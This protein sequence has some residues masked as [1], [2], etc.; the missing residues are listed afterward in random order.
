[1]SIMDLGERF[2]RR[3]PLGTLPT[4]LH[5]A[6]LLSEVGGVEVDLKRDDLLGD[7]LT[8]TKMRALSF[9]LWQAI[10]DR[11]TDLITIGE[12]TSNQCR[13]VAMLGA[14]YGMTPH[15]LLRKLKCTGGEADSNLMIMRMHGARLHFLEEDE[16]RLHGMT[17]KRLMS[18]VR[19]AK[20]KAL[21]VPFGCGG[22]PGVLGIVGLFD[23][24]A[25]QHDGRA[26][27]SHIV[28]PT[29]SG[30]TLFGLDLAVQLREVLPQRAPALVGVS[31]ARDEA[32]LRGQLD[33]LYAK[34]NAALGVNFSRRE[35]LRVTERWS[36]I[37]PAVVLEELQRVALSYG[38]MADPVYVLPAVLEVERMIK[39]GEL[40]A[41][42]RVL[43][44][45][46]GACRTLQAT[47]Q[48]ATEVRHDDL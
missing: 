19:K 10:E 46:S 24:L 38:V 44:L 45:V 15:I 5:R 27:Y 25:A 47:R 30:S 20:G 6:D 12:P 9:I 28:V 39:S 11:V 18:R 14:R 33:T 42:A 22:V 13:L 1:V 34:T 7:W 29:G 26:P 48:K 41:G 4:P 23:E 8:G 31:V 16:W 3:I 17:V 32:A 2:D 36:E 21:F 35:D 43:L 37:A 40:E